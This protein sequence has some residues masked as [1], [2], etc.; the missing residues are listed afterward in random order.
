[1]FLSI[2]FSSFL[3]LHVL[4][5]RPQC[6]L[7]WY[8]ENLSSDQHSIFPNAV[9]S[10]MFLLQDFDLSLGFQL[11]PSVQNVIAMVVHEDHVSNGRRGGRSCSHLLRK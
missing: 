2:T 6:V 8:L 4:P 5:V 10:H 3:F 1:M 7:T 11:V 9:L